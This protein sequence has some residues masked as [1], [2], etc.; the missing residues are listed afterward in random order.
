MWNRA[1]LAAVL[2]AAAC[3]ASTAQEPPAAPAN[4]PA[5]A[6]AQSSNPVGVMVQVVISRYQGEKKVGSLPYASVTANVQ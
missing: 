6:R 1:I 4:Q 3:G 5:S 2:V